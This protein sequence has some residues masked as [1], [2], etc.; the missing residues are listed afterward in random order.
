MSASWRAMGVAD[1]DSVLAIAEVVHPDYPEDRAVF[2]ERLA[3]FPDGCR[4]A[5]RGNSVVGYAVMHPD[6][7]GAPVPLDSLLG[8]LPEAADCLYLHDVALLP[9][10]QR[11]GL[12][13]AALD[14]AHALAAARGIARLA[15]T[16]TPSAR[17]YWERLGFSPSDAGGEKLAARLASY[18]EGLVYMT[19]PVRPS[20]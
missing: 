12:G 14:R 10:A 19:A 1:L 15:L 13:T 18:G 7:L 3:L 11:T 5:V 16:A 6:Q 2:A 9:A 17:G 4:I 20:R 8:S